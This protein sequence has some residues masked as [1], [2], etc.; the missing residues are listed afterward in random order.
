[1]SD[2]EKICCYDPD[3]YDGMAF[4]RWLADITA[5]GVEINWDDYL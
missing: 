4:N 1:M 3:G 2:V 5:N